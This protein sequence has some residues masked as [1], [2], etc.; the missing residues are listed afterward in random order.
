[1]GNDIIRASEFGLSAL[2]ADSEI[3]EILEEALAGESVSLG[4]LERVKWPTGGGTKFERTI[5]GNDE[6]VASITGVVIHQRMSRSYW[7]DPEPSEGT[8]PDCSSPDAKWGYGAPGDDLRAQNPPK[9]CEVCPNAQ[10]GSAPPKNGQPQR[11][12]A[13]KLMRDF[14][15]LT[16]GA[17]FPLIVS[18]PPASLGQAKGYVVELASHGIRYYH[19]VSELSLVKATNKGGQPYAEARLK[20]VGRLDDESKVGVDA[21][22][23]RMVPS[24]QQTRMNAD[25][26]AEPVADADTDAEEV[27]GEK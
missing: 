8:Q 20:M 23:E 25:G 15:V 18:V 14:F 10:F 17:T 9:G 11:G 27:D 13:C 16:P 19:V 12:Q 1:M 6:S 7:S 24:L 3:A 5:L 21:Y 26:P 22:R 4:D 2:D